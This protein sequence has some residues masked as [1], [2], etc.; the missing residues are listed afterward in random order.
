MSLKLISDHLSPITSPILH[1][2]PN[3]TTNRGFHL[4]GCDGKLDFRQKPL[5]SYSVNSDYFFYEIGDMISIGDKNGLLYCFPP[6]GT[7]VVAKTRLA[8]EELYKIKK[9]SAL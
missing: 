4:T 6:E 1:P 9:N 5:S 2:V 8:A 7:D 3:K